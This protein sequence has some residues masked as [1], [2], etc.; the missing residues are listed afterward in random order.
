[1]ISQEEA[2]AIAEELKKV[3]DSKPILTHAGWRIDSRTK[4][5]MDYYNANR[6]VLSIP[7]DWADGYL[8]PF[9][10]NCNPCIGKVV[11]VLLAPKNQIL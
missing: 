2:I 8:I 5:M 4:D 11:Q 7:D 6:K 3:R 10:I 1:M 9:S